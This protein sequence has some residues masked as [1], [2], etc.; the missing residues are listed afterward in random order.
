M[1]EA[2][3]K[4]RNVINEIEKLQDEIAID[5]HSR[6]SNM[7]TPNYHQ[8]SESARLI[9]C[10]VVLIRYKGEVYPALRSKE[11]MLRMLDDNIEFTIIDWGGAKK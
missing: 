2:L 10:A 5:M 11:A 4:I 6:E 8:L 1:T 9:G 7:E 3:E